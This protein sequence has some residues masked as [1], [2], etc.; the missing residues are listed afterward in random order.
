MSGIHYIREWYT[1]HHSRTSTYLKERGMYLQGGAYNT[2]EE[3]YIF[4]EGGICCVRGSAYLQESYVSSGRV[5]ITYR[6]VYELSE[7]DTWYTRSSI[8]LIKRVVC[9]VMEEYMSHQEWCIAH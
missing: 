7:K 1:L 5:Y 6:E 3:V 4:S 2:L 8:Y 9:I